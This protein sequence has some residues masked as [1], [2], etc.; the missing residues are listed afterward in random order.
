MTEK[1][2]II[3]GAGIA[4]LAAAL[5]GWDRDVLLLERAAAFDPVG[6]G[7]QLGPNAVSALQKLGAWDAVQPFTN[8]PPEIHMRDGISG[9]LLKRLQLG[10][11]FERRFSAPY[12]TAHRADVHRALL[13]VVK[14]R[15]NTDIRLNVQ[16]IADG[17]FDGSGLIAADGVHSQLRQKIFPG[18][19]AI[20]SGEVFHRALLQTWP[21]LR[22]VDMA[23]VNVWLLPDAHVVHYPV[24]NPG[25]LNLV[26]VTP[27]NVSPMESVRHAADDVKEIVAQVGST[28]PWPGLYVEPLKAWNAGRTLLIGDAAHATLPYLA[29]G[30]AM[31]LEDAA[32][33]SQVLQTRSDVSDAFARVSSLRITR[34]AKLHRASLAAGLTYHMG[35]IPARARNLVLRALPQQLMWQSLD[36]LYGFSFSHR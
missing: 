13:D 5:A 32:T 23:C 4:G 15:A 34:T 36:W 2:I 14:A 27:R 16:V 8:S 31:S 6:A 7:L 11:N 33:L 9:K 30:A 18:T 1:P 24:G 29:Q 12:R 25:K 22:D 21:A 19:A 35:G 3:A 28:A 20:D 26:V 10:K 17:D